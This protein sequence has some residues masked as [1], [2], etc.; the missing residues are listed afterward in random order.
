MIQAATEKRPMRY[1]I[2]HITQYKYTD[3]V[4]ICQNQ[5]RMLPGSRDHLQVHS[6][7][8]RIEPNP[9]TLQRHVDY[10]GNQVES[11][12]IESLHQALKVTVTSD[13]T[14][15]P[16]TLPAAETTRPWEEVLALVQGRQDETTF[17]AGEFCFDSPRIHRREALA[18][19]ARGSFSPG[20]PILA[21][22]QELTKRIHADF[23]YD[24][25]A[26]HVN[27]SADEAFAL[28][29]GVCQDFAQ[30]QIG[31]LRSLG[32]PAR[33]VSGY[34]RTIP[35][36]GK[37]RMVGGDQSHAWLSVYG[38]PDVG[39]IDLDPTNACVAG[40]DHIA[41]CVGRDY[42]DVSPMRGV[43]LGGGQPVLT[44]SVDVVPIEPVGG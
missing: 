2:T 3:P 30:I 20:R 11:F 16:L 27:T 38:G 18:S 33:Y 43:V 44:V 14:V 13:V 21:A 4:A 1:K 28:R 9:D 25:T 37:A 35:P 32:L 41:V 23:R 12:A 10:F 26:T 34:V 5:L 17:A 19:Y 7:Q 6:A 36:P 31:C 40:M 39:W 29:A 22:S 15:M 42:G 8:S 24:T